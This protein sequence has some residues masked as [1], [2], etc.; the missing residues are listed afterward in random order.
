MSVEIYKTNIKDWKHARALVRSIHQAFPTYRANFDLE[1]CDHILR[2][3]TDNG[4]IFSS[5]LILL[6]E[7]SG[8]TAEVLQEAIEN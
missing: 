7:D 5:G 1:D 2:V 3:A 6:L 8:C 4:E